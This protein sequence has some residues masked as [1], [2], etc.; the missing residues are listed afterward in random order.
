MPGIEMAA[1]FTFLR[2]LE[3]MGATYRLGYYTDPEFS[4][5]HGWITVHVDVTYTERWEVDFFADGTVNVD[6]FELTRGDEETPSL[7]LLLTE[8]RAHRQ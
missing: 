3:A 5:K 4:A 2:E 1:M 8:L 7:D 6:R